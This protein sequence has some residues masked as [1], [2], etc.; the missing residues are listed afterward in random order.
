PLF[1]YTTLFRSRRRPASSADRPVRAVRPTG[2]AW[3]CPPWSDRPPPGT[4]LLDGLALVA[5]AL[6]PVTGWDA[7]ASAVPAG[8][9]TPGATASVLEFERH[10]LPFPRL[11]SLLFPLL[12]RPVYP[13]QHVWRKLILAT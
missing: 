13:E 10:A 1:P 5:A 8:T 7:V 9:G 6:P 2:S 11:L 3:S 4:P 12:P